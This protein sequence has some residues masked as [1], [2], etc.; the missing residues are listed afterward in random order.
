M[1]RNTGKGGH[2]CLEC[3]TSESCGGGVIENVQN[4]DGQMLKLRMSVGTR[5]GHG[6]GVE[7]DIQLAAIVLNS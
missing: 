5:R 4:R 3:S 1:Q 2:K 6:V 7:N